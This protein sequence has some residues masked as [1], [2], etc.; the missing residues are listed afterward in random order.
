M[1]TPIW[2]SG[3]TGSSPDALAFLINGSPDCCPELSV[4]FDK[5]A[6]VKDNDG[7]DKE[8]DLWQVLNRKKFW[9]P[10][11]LSDDPDYAVISH[12]FAEATRLSQLLKNDTR[13][14]GLKEHYELYAEKCSLL[15]KKQT[16]HGMQIRTA[17]L[18]S[19]L[20]WIPGSKA[21]WAASWFAMDYTS[22]YN[23]TDMSIHANIDNGYGRILEDPISGNHQMDDWPPESGNSP[24]GYVSE[25]L[26]DKIS[27][28]FSKHLLANIELWL[29]L[30]DTGVYFFPPAQFLNTKHVMDI[31]DEL[32]IQPPEYEWVERWVNTF[33]TKL[34]LDAPYCRDLETIN[35]NAFNYLLK[36]IND[37]IYYTDAEKTTMLDKINSSI[38]VFSN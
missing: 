5:W 9:A 18:D 17:N 36:R 35:E 37:D 12:E 4:C 22:I 34:N 7:W 32:E 24:N 14:V 27:K 10:L 31:Y 30:K 11:E 38:E 1:T 19:A 26:V 29:K 23:W 33:R 25:E 6:D 2:I 28:G 16:W 8:S 13:M 20:E 15:P 21:V 3:F